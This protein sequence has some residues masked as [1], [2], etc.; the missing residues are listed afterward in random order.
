MK[1]LLK[2]KAALL[3]IA[4]S[5][6]S[7]INTYGQKFN[8]SATAKIKNNDNIHEI[9]KIGDKNVA[10][11]SEYTIKKDF[12]VKKVNYY[13]FYI[14]RKNDIELAFFDNN[15]NYI[16]STPIQFKY[17]VLAYYFGYINQNQI[18]LVYSSVQNKKV[19]VYADIFDQNGVYKQSKLLYESAPL[20]IKKDDE[21]GTGYYT[22]IQSNYDN[23]FVID[24]GKMLLYFDEQL[25]KIWETEAGTETIMD[26]NFSYDGKFYSII[27]EKKTVHIKCA[28]YKNKTIVKKEI[29][30]K[31]ES[32]V[33]DFTLKISQEQKAIYMACIFGEKNDKSTFSFGPPKYIAYYSNG[34]LF[35]KFDLTT[36]NEV[37]SKKVNYNDQVLSVISEEKKI[38]KLKGLEWMSIVDLHINQSGEPIAVIQKDYYE[39]FQTRDQYGKVIQTRYDYVY[40]DLVIIKSTSNNNDNQVALKRKT[41]GA[42]L[43]D[44]MLSMTSFFYDDKLTILYNEGKS[45]YK[46]IKYEFDASLNQ[47]SKTE[48]PTY[49]EHSVY[50]DIKHVAFKADKKYLIWG[51]EGKNVACVQLEF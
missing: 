4:L 19:T 41:K 12:L 16:S 15:Y 27:S 35:K 50:L 45:S 37:E 2:F 23:T 3:I 29:D 39:E 33:D 51:R 47:L 8:W 5:S 42:A 46:L 26:A 17:K 10:L 36:L 48:I 24:Q 30:L 22:V 25:N 11:M 38:E 31:N 32:I 43:Y 9:G 40:E 34:V 49:K 13:N 7:S 44:Y 6:L 14:E 1:N 28:D 18:N 21:V 20:N